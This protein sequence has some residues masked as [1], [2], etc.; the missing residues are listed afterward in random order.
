MI[1]T[2]ETGFAERLSQAGVAQI[3]GFGA[4]NLTVAFAASGKGVESTRPSTPTSPR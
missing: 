3:G 4:R 1:L 2:A